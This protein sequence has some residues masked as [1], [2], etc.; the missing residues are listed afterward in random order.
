MEARSAGAGGGLRTMR[1]KAVEATK[2]IV[3]DLPGSTSEKSSFGGTFAAWKSAECGIG[4]SL[5]I[6]TSPRMSVWSWWR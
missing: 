4:Q 3:F 2:L 5:T 1:R 6:V